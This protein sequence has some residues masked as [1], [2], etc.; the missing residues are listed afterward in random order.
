LTL[1]STKIATAI[2]YESLLPE[3][4]ENAFSSGAKIY[5]ASVANS[6][7]GVEKAF[8]H[9]PDIARKYSMSVMMSNYV[10]QCDNF[11]SAGKTSVWNNK[12]TLAGQLNDKDEGILIFDVDTQETIEKKIAE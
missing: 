9:F 5:L 12:G 6:A 2:C 4:S 10:G 7:G 1:N 8:K 11:Q 3:H